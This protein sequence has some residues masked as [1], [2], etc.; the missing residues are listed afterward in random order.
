LSYKYKKKLE[1][2]KKKEI[3]YKEN[4]KEFMKFKKENKTIISKYYKLSN[5]RWKDRRNI[6]HAERDLIGILKL[7]PIYIKK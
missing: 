2:I 1:Y 7:Q 5:Q 4:K 6:K 3:K